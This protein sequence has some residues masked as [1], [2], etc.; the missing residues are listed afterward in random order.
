MKIPA[1]RVRPPTASGASGLVPA[2][3]VLGIVIGP[4]GVAALAPLLLGLA[5]LFFRNAAEFRRAVGGPGG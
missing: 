1:V 5:V 3:V 4:W 2:S